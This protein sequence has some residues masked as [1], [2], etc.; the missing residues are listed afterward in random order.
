MHHSWSGSCLKPDIAP[1]NSSCPDDSCSNKQP[2]QKSHGQALK[3]ET[4]ADVYLRT[5]I[6][7][8]ARV[9]WHLDLTKKKRKVFFFPASVR[10][11]KL[12]LEDVQWSHLKGQYWG[13]STFLLLHHVRILFLHPKHVQC[14]FDSFRHFWEIIKSPVATM[15]LCKMHPAISWNSTSTELIIPMTFQWNASR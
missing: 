7:L 5:R 12:K 14:C 6:Q 9:T 4:V 3:K 15:Q 11:L 8:V 2:V 13:K 1:G 10:W